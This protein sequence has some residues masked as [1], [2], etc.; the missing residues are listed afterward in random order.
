M[1]LRVV[2]DDKGNCKLAKMADNDEI[3]SDL[4]PINNSGDIV[5]PTKRRK[6][7][8]IKKRRGLSSTFKRMTIGAGRKKK[9]SKKAIKV[10][11][12]RRSRVKRSV[13]AGKRKRR[14]TLQ[15][16]RRTIKRRKR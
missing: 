2:C 1:V 7:V 3:P 8:G 15:K 5:A 9:R 10:R 13:G 12:Q 4:V 6:R 14:N 16:V 11:V